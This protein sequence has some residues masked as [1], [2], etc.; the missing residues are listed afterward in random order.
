MRELFT[1][2][3]LYI[4]IL[5]LGNMGNTLNTYT[6]TYQKQKYL[7]ILYKKNEFFISR[8]IYVSY[9][10]EMKKYCEFCL[11]ARIEL[12]ISMLS[13]ILWIINFSCWGKYFTMESHFIITLLTGKYA[14]FS[15]FSKKI[16]YWSIFIICHVFRLYSQR[17]LTAVWRTP[18]FSPTKIDYSV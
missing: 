8:K 6:Y 9:D 17:T 15:S 18:K 2:N 4:H 11:N 16:F 1:L 5:M 12:C 7:A 14:K 13:S 10:T 3:S